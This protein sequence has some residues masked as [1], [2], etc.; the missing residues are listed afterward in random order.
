MR[1]LHALGTMNPGGIETWLLQV[2]K[3]IDRDRFQFDFCTFGPK[4]G[5]YASEVEKLG[6]RM[7]PCPIGRNVWS[8]R[9]RFRRIL[10]EG[11]YDIVH[12][13]VTLF[14]GAVLRWA[15]AEKVPI[16]IAHSHNSHD[17]KPDTRVRRNYRRLMKSW[18]ARY[19]THG[20]AASQAAAVELFGKNWQT[21]SRF[22]VLYYGIDAHPFQKPSVCGEIRRELGVPLGAPVVGHVG[23]FEAQ[24]NHHFLLEVAGE[25]LKKRPDIHFL[26]VGD[27]PLRREIEGR[28][29]E[30]GLSRRMHFVGIRTDVPRLMR[31]AMDFFLFPSLFEGLGLCLVEAQAAGLNCLVSNMVPDEVAL[32]PELL[33][34]LPLS[35]GPNLWASR[36]IGRLDV[37]RADV[38]TTAN[39]VRQGR[40]SIQQSVRDL[41]CVYSSARLSADRTFVEEHA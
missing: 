25:I 39:E 34:F 38:T 17:D 40:F 5:L 24:K 18:I 23:R 15:K 16:R 4:A 28:A 33:E 8:F 19:A 2:L 41:C 26:L 13:H 36:L 37:P 35:A 7:V 32:L 6:G 14:S 3:F 20:L 21:D 27:G 10:R 12:S 11:D 9:S 31:D 22:R 30:M 1:I 29:K